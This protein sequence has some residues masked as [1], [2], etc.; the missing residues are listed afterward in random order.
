MLHHSQV[1]FTLIQLVSLYK[2]QLALLIL[3][4]L[5]LLKHLFKSVFALCLCFQL[6]IAHLAPVAWR[7]DAS[8]TT[9]Y[10]DSSTH[11]G[12]NRLAIEGQTD[13]M[14]ITCVICHMICMLYYQ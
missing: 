3:F 6:G 10:I 14:M 8:H 13:H 5:M 12:F 9:S 7:S 1:L 4:V 11:S 2:L